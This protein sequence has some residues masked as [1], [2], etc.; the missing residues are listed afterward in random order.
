MVIRFLVN[1][2]VSMG[3]VITFDKEQVLDICLHT[4]WKYGYDN[5]TIRDL[6]QLTGLSGRSLIHSFGDKRQIFDLC[7]N[8][9]LTFVRK[10]VQDLIHDS[11]G[12]NKFFEGFTLCDSTDVRN[13]GCF[14]LN[15][16]YG[17]LKGDQRIIQAFEKFKS[18]VTDFFMAQLTLN[19]IPNPTSKAFLLF[20]LFLSGLTK[21]SIYE[22]A[23]QMNY[24]FT[25]VKQL[26][27]IWRE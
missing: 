8:H 13:H 7:L 26:L 21:I 6:Q 10:V 24:T 17:G 3:R 20:D 23:T 9:Y 18:C 27:S 2:N 1:T 19:D 16:I 22:D 14:V 5:T 12:L 15:S 25:D 4:F 11:N